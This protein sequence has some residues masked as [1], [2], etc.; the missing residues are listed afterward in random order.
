GTCPGR[1]PPTSAPS[2]S[3]TG[4]SSACSTKP[5]STYRERRLL[6]SESGPIVRPVVKGLLVATALAATLPALPKVASLPALRSHGLTVKAQAATDRQPGNPAVGFGS[7]WVPSSENEIVDR[8]DQST[9]KLQAR[10]RAG[11]THAPG[12]NEYF[13]SIAVG[14]TSVWAASDAGN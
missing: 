1:S 14:A 12:Q 11:S 4:A 10:I 6:A 8:Y 3:S 5:E 13:D 9:A 7:V 2:T